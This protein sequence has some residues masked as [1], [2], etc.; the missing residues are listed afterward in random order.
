MYIGELSLRNI[1]TFEQAALTFQV[2]GRPDPR[3]GPD[4]VT[5]IVGLNGSGKSTVLRSIALAAINPILS[6]SGFVPRSIVRRKHGPHTNMGGEIEAHFSFSEQDKGALDPWD[7]TLKLLASPSGWI[8]RTLITQTESPPW[9]ESLWESDSTGFFVVGYGATR[10]VESARSSSSFTSEKERHPRYLRVAS[11]FEDSIV[12]KPLSSWLP[13]WSNPGRRKQVIDLLNTIIGS[14]SL[15]EQGLSPNETQD[16]ELPL[17]EVGGA[18]VPFD[19]LS[20]G[21]RAFIGWLA[22]L[23]FYITRGAPTGKRLE[24]TTGIALIDEIDLHMHPQWQREVLPRLAKAMP[25]MQFICTTHS[26][27]VIGSVHQKNVL[28]L[29]EE[30][31]ATVVEPVPIEAYGLSSDQILTSPY[32]GLDSTRAPDFVKQLDAVALRAREGDGEQAK[33]LLRMLTL[34]E[35]ASTEADR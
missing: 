25:R 10:R 5:L 24:D 15:S 30:N 13:N 19:A 26:P 3:P 6:S 20:D 28:V 32:F 1:R 22:D 29:R 12:L 8:D 4:N 18:L 14:A 33:H 21:Y 17:F 11:L 7:S 34:G 9:I 35:S 27:L 23:L 16:L 31:G 2:P